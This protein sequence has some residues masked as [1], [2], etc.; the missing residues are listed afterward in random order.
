MTGVKITIGFGWGAIIFIVLLIFA[1]FVYAKSIDMT[2]AF[3]LIVFLFW[4]ISGILGLIPI[5]GPIIA[6]FVDTG[7][8]F[9]FVAGLTGIYWTWILGLALWIA[10][11]ASAFI[12]LI[13]TI[14]I[15]G[16]MAGYS[17]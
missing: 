4:T 17:H 9:S 15:L 12:S 8:I 7:P 3:I 5:A 14:I 11:I 6:Y 2:L 13:I 10:I 16:L 1:F